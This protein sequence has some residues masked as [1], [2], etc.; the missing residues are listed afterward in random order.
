MNSSTVSV[1]PACVSGQSMA[2]VML[3]A[4]GQP[5]QPAPLTST[6]LTTLRMAGPQPPLGSIR[7]GER[8]G[9]GEVA[10][11]SCAVPFAAGV[12]QAGYLVDADGQDVE[13]AALV[14]VAV[15]LVI[16]NQCLGLVADGRCQSVMRTSLRPLA[17]GDVEGLLAGRSRRSRSSGVM[18]PTCRPLTCT[19]IDLDGI[20][21]RLDGDLDLAPG[22]RA[23]RSLAAGETM[24]KR[25]T[26]L[27]QQVGQLEGGARRPRVPPARRRPG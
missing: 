5:C 24:R 16:E 22:R 21:H 27:R 11:R 13:R 23:A 26:G 20:G 3:L 6:R 1:S 19:R 2:S 15:A 17:S 7:P 4:V 25:G 10:G 14:E 18:L 8:I 9:A 12:A